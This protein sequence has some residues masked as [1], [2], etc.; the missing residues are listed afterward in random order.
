MVCLIHNLKYKILFQHF[1]QCIFKY[2]LFHHISVL[3]HHTK[4]L[5]L[6]FC[7]ILLLKVLNRHVF[8]NSLLFFISIG[9]RFYITK[10]LQYDN[11][12]LNQI[13]F[14]LSIVTIL[15]PLCFLTFS[16]VFPKTAV[17]IN[18]KKSFFIQKIS[19]HSK[20]FFDF[21]LR[22]MFI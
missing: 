3:H 6:T 1:L 21:F 5:T 11:L 4:T 13:V 15:V 12:V 22:S 8:H 10:T 14:S 19:I 18:L 17:F 9:N 7:L 2:H 20:S 16:I